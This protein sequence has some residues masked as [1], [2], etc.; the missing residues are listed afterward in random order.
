MRRPQRRRG[1]VRTSGCGMRCIPV[2]RSARM[3]PNMLHIFCGP[4]PRL[5]PFAGGGAFISHFCRRSRAERRWVRVSRHYR[6]RAAAART[7]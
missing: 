5:A 2:C 7:S 1:A 4:P 3:Q 6:Q